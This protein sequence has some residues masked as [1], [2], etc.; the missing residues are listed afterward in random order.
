MKF[1]CT[2]LSVL[3]LTTCAFGACAEAE[4]VAFADVAVE[5]AIRE[6]LGVSAD[7]PLTTDDLAMILEFD[8]EAGEIQTLEDFALCKNLESF[9]L[10]GSKT[11]AYDLTPFAGLEKL[12]FF[13]V[14]G[15][16]LNTAP[17]AALPELTALQIGGSVT[18]LDLSPL[19]GRDNLTAFFLT[20][21]AL[22]GDTDLTPL[23][24]HANLKQATL[25]KLREGELRPLLESWPNLQYLNVSGGPV[26]TDDLA[27]LATRKL[28]VLSLNPDK[29]IDDFSPLAEQKE[30]FRVQA[31]RM[32]DA[33]LESLA[34]SVPGLQKLYL[35]GALLIDFSPL[36]R[37]ENLEQINMYVGDGLALRE[38]LKDTAVE[39]NN[40]M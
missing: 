16:V 2:L 1:L 20:K 5:Q 8:G 18:Q 3:M 39:I 19:A 22:E 26:T 31:G 12:R 4:T 23:K 24:S 13:R 34:E 25:P 35:N 14:D 17:V 32:T 11:P 29:P 30:L 28:Q 37:L 15:N 27:A 21:R 6:T 38:T 10:R 33:G 36:L 9:I 40:E 7:A